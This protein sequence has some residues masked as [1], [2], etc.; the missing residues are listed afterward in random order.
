MDLIICTMFYR[1]V[2]C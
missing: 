2:G 1:A